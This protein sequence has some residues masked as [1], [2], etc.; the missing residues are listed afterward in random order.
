MKKKVNRRIL[1]KKRYLLPAILL[2]FIILVA[3]AFFIYKWVVKSQMDE[4]TKK[5]DS[6]VVETG[7]YIKEDTGHQIN[8]YYAP[9]DN[10]ISVYQL[11]PEEIE[12]K[13]FTYYD[14]NVQERLAGALENLKKENS[15]SLQSPLAVWNPYGTGSNGLYIY[16]QE[17]EAAEIWYTISVENSE[18]SDYTAQASVSDGSDKEFLLIGLVP[19]EK[20]HVTITLK[21]SHGNEL[22]N[23]SFFLDVPDTISGYNTILESAS[24]QSQEQLSDGLYYTLGTQ[25]YYGYM[26]FF[27]ND[28]ILRYEML[29]DGYKADRVLMDGD[30]MICCVSSNQIGKINAL[31][32]VT[33]LYTLDGYVMHHDFNWGDDG[34]LVVLATKNNASDHR[35]MDRVLQIDMETGAVEEIIDLK[36]LFPDYYG[37]T[38]KVEET[39]SFFWQ[40]GTRDWMHINTIE[41]LEDSSILLSS[42]ETSTII[43]I[44]DAY[45]NPCV[46][47][48]IGDASFWEDTG[49]EELCYEKDGDFTEQYGQHT[50]TYV[51]ADE[52]DS[53]Q[54]YLLMY[55]NNYYTNSTRKDDFVP[56]LNENVSQ[57]LTDEDSS[58]YI[59][60]YLVDENSRTYSLTWS[61]EVPY[62]SIVSSVQQY[63]GNYVVNSGVAQT[64]GEYDASGVLIKSFAYESSFQG[65]RVMKDT[66]SG[67]WFQ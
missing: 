14:M 52:L 43:K 2:G 56:D 44:S 27:D 6:W 17:Q 18:Y 24:G 11:I 55:N 45:N 42:R 8:I 33:A 9:F 51:E 30:E 15:Y 65:Y 38:K 19:G 61:F 26:F 48:L 20:N 47:Y 21:D 13:D 34:S 32:R 5:R 35:V 60:V 4:E 36:Q 58:S 3:A 59:Y 10:E 41:S 37:K 28:G 39:S 62:S 54:Y 31:G 53:G 40:A 64:W 63:D 16:F 29:L 12:S 1:L 66:F 7:T 57:K 46:E 67:Y 25:G 23:A 22:E 50:V 49:Y